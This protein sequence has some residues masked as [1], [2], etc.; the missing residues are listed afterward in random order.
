MTAIKDVSLRVPIHPVLYK[1]WDR[2]ME[3]IAQRA[4]RNV[5]DEMQNV[6]HAV[7]HAWVSRGA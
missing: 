5:G 6:L 1:V 7:R 2:N 3:Y 4:E